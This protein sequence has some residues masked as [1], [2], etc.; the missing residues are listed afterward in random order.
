MKHVNHYARYNT[1]PS[2]WLY[3]DLKKVPICKVTEHMYYLQ[4][5][6]H[7]FEPVLGK[8]DFFVVTTPTHHDRWI[9]ITTLNF[10]TAQEMVEEIWG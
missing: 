8:P 6:F 7:P 9:Q 10:I 4:D 3:E 5:P 2:E 1:T